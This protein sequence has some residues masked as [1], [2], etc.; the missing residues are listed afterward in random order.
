MEAGSSRRRLR[1]DRAADAAS[2]WPS[3]RELWEHRDLLYF[4]ARREVSVRYKQSVIGVA[5]GGPAAAAARGRVQRLLR[6]PGEG[7]VRDGRALP[8]VR[9]VR[10]WCSGCSSPRAMS[11]RHRE[12]GR[13]REL[14]S[15]VYFPRMI[16]PLAAVAPAAG[17]LRA[18]RSSSCCVTLVVYG[19]VPPIQ[20]FLMPARRARWRWRRRSASGCG[21][22]RSTSATA[23]FTSRSRS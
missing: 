3:L 22:R 15:K 10:A 21:C 2:R 19:I 7:A 9:A 20:I 4:L 13:E 18:S 11:A 23:T 1:G 6:A 12:H 17:R 14:I 8:G 16:I 5:L